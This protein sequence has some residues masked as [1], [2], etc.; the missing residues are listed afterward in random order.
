MNTISRCAAFGASICLGLIASVQGAQAAETIAGAGSSA[1]APVYRIWA[2][3]YAKERGPTLAYEPI[4]SGAGMARIAKRSV[5]FGASDVIA[6]RDDLKK[7]DLVMFPTVISGVVPV[8]N[9]PQ[10]A[11]NALKLSGEVLAQIFLGQ[12]TQWD[13][14]EIKALNAGL[15]LPAQ[16]IQRV[17]RSDGSG[18][19]YHF[20]DYLSS[21]NATWKQRYGAATR[22][23]WTGTVTAVKGTTAVSD[24]MRSTPGAIGYIDYNYVI[25]D[26]LVAVSMKN[27]EGQFVNAGVEGFREA[28]IHSAWYTAGD[29]SASLT[30]LP[31]V[32][33]WP[34]TMGT[35]IAVPRVAAQNDGTERA[36][37][38]VMWAYLH[39]DALARQAK[40]VPLPNKVQASAY[41]EISK[42]LGSH[43]E[44][45]GAPL[46]GEFIK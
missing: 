14:P 44:I 15:K 46:L 29:F 16:S 28:V 19:T 6:S 45:L 8:V 40:F 27:V 36:L 1:A 22:L 35:Y 42:V 21:V 23:D 11:P 18:T 5:D 30:N 25:D 7:N 9:L 31:G 26:K 10:I 12:I 37:K 32:R 24:A 41:R 4:G 3:E 33:S 38:F 2:A 20:S 17:V 34:L 43:G 13:A 39:G